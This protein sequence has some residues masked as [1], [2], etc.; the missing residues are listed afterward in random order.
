MARA[1]AMKWRD[2][3]GR[4]AG[5]RAG[6]GRRHRVNPG[7]HAPAGPAPLAQ[8]VPLA[9]CRPPPHPRRLPG[10]LANLQTRCNRRSSSVRRSAGCTLQGPH[11]HSYACSSIGSA[12]PWSSSGMLTAPSA[13]LACQAPQHYAA[14]SQVREALC[15]P[16]EPTRSGRQPAAC[17]GSQ[18]WKQ[19]SA[20]LSSPMQL[21]HAGVVKLSLQS[22]RL[23]KPAV[24]AT[25]P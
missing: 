23:E 6:S 12:R 15:R 4:G 5:S 25:A 24:A 19:G 3:R 18:Q 7:P 1:T 2:S 16:Q 14:H 9:S 20:L 10:P 11:L 17:G 21:G 8:T 13:Q 22:S